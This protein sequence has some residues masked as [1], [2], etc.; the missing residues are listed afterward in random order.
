[1][2]SLN[3]FELTELREAI[4]YPP[5]ELFI[6]SKLASDTLNVDVFLKNNKVRPE[7][8]WRVLASL[9]EQGE[10]LTI[11]IISIS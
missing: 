10:N 9:Q 11:S 6:R 4:Q 8:L 1:M 2:K 7:A 3:F 5:L